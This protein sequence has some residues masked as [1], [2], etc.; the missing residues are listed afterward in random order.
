MIQIDSRKKDPSMQ[1]T[2]TV[3]NSEELN[4]ALLSA[5][6]GEVI[7]LVNTGEDYA[8]SLYK[9]FTPDSMVT[10][11]AQDLENPPILHS[12]YMREG[13]NLTFDG[14]QIGG[15]AEQAADR[16]D[17]L[18][19]FYMHDVENVTITNSKLIGYAEGYAET[20]EDLVEQIVLIRGGTN[21]EFTDNLVSNTLYGMTVT[22][23]V[24]LTITGNEITQIQGD[25]VRLAGVQDVLIDDNYIHDFLSSSNQLVHDDMIQIWSKGTYTQ[26]QNVQITNNI[27][28]QGEGEW[29]QTIF[30]GNE[31]TR[32][33]GWT[34]DDLHENIVI[35]NNY[36]HNSHLHAIYLQG[37]DGGRVANNTIIQDEEYVEQLLADAAASGIHANPG[38]YLPRIRAESNDFNIE[39]VDNKVVEV[40]FNG[41]GFVVE[42]NSLDAIGANLDQPVSCLLY[43]S[44]SPRDR[45]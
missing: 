6:G 12:V 7:E 42:G 40:I 26:T 44:P 16:P 20:S 32:V 17:W 9:N 23:T 27:L 30:I 34:E 39:I 45:G 28:D 36:I 22:E 33:D 24:G 14:L 18:T 38:T 2:I 31:K 1:K 41:E 25:G 4:T 5:T 10:I 37:V 13:Q 15:N 11:T 3:R 29:S 35:E 19:D 8:I 43:T 21:I